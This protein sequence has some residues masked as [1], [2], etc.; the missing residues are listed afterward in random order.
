V[1]NI[2]SLELVIDDNDKS[3][4]IVFGKGFQPLGLFCD[5]LSKEYSF[6]TLFYGHLRPSL[7]SSYQKIMQVNPTSINKKFAISSK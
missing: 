1:Q 2:L 5:A 7:A 6:P 4:T 3:I